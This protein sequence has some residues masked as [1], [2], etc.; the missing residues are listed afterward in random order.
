MILVLHLSD[1]ISQFLA[2]YE[3]ITSIDMEALSKRSIVHSK[4][5]TDIRNRGTLKSCNSLIG[6]SLT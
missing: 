2:L 4:I 6:Q 5:M 1:W 3:I